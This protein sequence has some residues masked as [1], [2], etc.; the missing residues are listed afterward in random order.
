[1]RTRK[2]V[3]RRRIYEVI[4]Q[5]RKTVFD[6]LSKYLEFRQNYPPSVVNISFLLDVW[7]RGLT[8][9]FVFDTLPNIFYFITS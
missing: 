6:H 7:K 4:Y 5:T 1:M 2:V 8:R 3:L 9:S